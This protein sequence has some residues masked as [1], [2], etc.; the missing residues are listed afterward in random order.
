MREIPSVA[1]IGREAIPPGE[2][3]APIFIDRASVIEAFV[4]LSQSTHGPS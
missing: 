4:D 1:R 2:E 3:K